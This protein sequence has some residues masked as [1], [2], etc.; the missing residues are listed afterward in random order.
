MNPFVKTFLV[1][2][3]CLEKMKVENTVIDKNFK[4]ICKSCF[5][6]RDE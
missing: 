1:C 5:V 4:V 6:N 2:E 3:N